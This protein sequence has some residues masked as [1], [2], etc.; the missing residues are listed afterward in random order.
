MQALKSREV[1][2][3]LREGQTGGFK[4]PEQVLER[5][6]G[7][8]R[9]GTRN[10]RLVWAT[11]VAWADRGYVPEASKLDPTVLAAL[12]RAV[13][14]VQVQ[15]RNKDGGVAPKSRPAGLRDLRGRE[16]RV[17]PADRIDQAPKWNEPDPL[18]RAGVRALDGLVVEELREINDGES[19]YV[20]SSQSMISEGVREQLESVG[21]YAAPTTRREV[22]ALLRHVEQRLALL[23]GKV[24]EDFDLAVQAE[25]EAVGIEGL[26]DASAE[27][28]WEQMGSSKED[29]AKGATAV[30]GGLDPKAEA[31]LLKWVA[32][33]LR[34]RLDRIDEG[35]L[36][37]LQVRDLTRTGEVVLR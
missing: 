34:E 4:T 33:Y 8:L 13:R 1:E 2:A 35:R 27:E 9:E 3:L 5:L 23:D 36:V 25:E 10:G 14:G 30:S 12:L 17:D 29:V 18:T 22:A 16:M 26:N 6:R 24:L 15:R 31:E 32:N 11:L 37:G 20:S 19:V 21:I 7:L 28:L